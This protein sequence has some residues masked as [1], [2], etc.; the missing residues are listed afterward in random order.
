MYQ[1]AINC[2]KCYV[3]IRFDNGPNWMYG[4]CKN[5]LH[6]C[7]V[8]NCFVDDRFR[9][10]PC[11][12]YV[13]YA[14]IILTNPLKYCICCLK[15]EKQCYKCKIQVTRGYDYCYYVFCESCAP[16]CGGNC[17]KIIT[18]WQKLCDYHYLCS[19]YP[20]RSIFHSSINAHR[21]VTI[22][23]IML[24]LRR[25]IPRPLIIAVIDFTFN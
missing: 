9:C 23:T 4:L 5:C 10:D 12:Q 25:Q 14:H 19:M 3:P 13:C 21:V 1:P 7:T 22:T 8:C 18:S 24:A 17:N 20:V 6:R 15:S 11:G 16:L 2:Y